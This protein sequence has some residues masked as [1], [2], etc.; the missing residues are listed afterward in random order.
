MT[1]SQDVASSSTDQL[2]QSTQG[3]A[4]SADTL[5]TSA[6]VAASALDGV[7]TSGTTGGATSTGGSF[8]NALFGSDPLTGFG[9]FAASLISRYLPILLRAGIN[10]IISNHDGT[11]YVRKDN[12]WLDQMLGLGSDETAR[13]LKVGEAVIPDYINSASGNRSD[14]PFSGSVVNAPDTS[15]IKSNNNS[16]LV[17][18]M[19]DLD[20]NGLDSASLR[21]ELEYI[22]QESANKVYSTLNR[23]IKVGGYRNVRTRYN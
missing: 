23:Y 7:A 5:S 1:T 14:T 15:M 13:I 10:K 19:G 11:N 9:N 18:D 16:S 3:A 17:I 2:S 20:V 6:D 8:L 22:K 21:S 12:S 4:T